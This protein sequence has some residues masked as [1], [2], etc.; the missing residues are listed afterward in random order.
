MTNKTVD[1]LTAATTIA[2]TDLLAIYPTGGPL[3]KVTFAIFKSL[4]ITALGSSYLIV[5]NNLSDLAS[6]STARANL[7]LGSVATLA[8]S[9]LFQVANNLSEV[10]NAATARTNLGAAAAASPTI[11]GGMTFSGTTKQNVQALAALDIDWSTAEVVTKSIAVNSTFTFS[12]FTS[13]KAQAVLV[14]LTISSS[15]VDTWPAAVTWPGGTKPTLG[16]GTHLIGLLT[17]DG[18]TTVEAMVGGI[19]FA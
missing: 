6:A 2:D 11:T 12:N 14:L 15:A 13:S 10:A 9:A 18:G 19:A 3:K 17:A 1:Q 7:G 5:S 8:S 16:N 4:V